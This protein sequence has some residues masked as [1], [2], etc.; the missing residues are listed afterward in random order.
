MDWL[1][2]IWLAV[3]ILMFIDFFLPTPWYLISKPFTV[4]AFIILLLAL[5]IRQIMR[6][7]QGLIDIISNPAI[8]AFVVTLIALYLFRKIEHRTDK[9][10]R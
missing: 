3:T 7:I 1:L 6:G 5:L 10:R 4:G 9:K 2:I 8:I